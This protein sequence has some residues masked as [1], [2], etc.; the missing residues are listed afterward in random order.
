MNGTDLLAEFRDKG[1]EA[2]FSELVRR[3]TNLVYSVA[4]RRVS[5]SALAQEVAQLV[6]IRLA[7]AVPKLR[8]DAELVAWLHR[9]TVHVSIDLWRS[10]MRRHAREEQAVAMQPDPAED[11]AWNEMAPVVDEAL[12]ALNDADRQAILLRFFEQKSMRD[13]ALAFGISEDAAKMRVSRALDRLRGQ[14]GGH[15][16][17]CASVLALGALLAERS[18]EAAPSQLVA[19]L[20]ALRIPA[21]AGAGAG[22]GIVAVAVAVAKSKL[23]VGAVAALVSGGAVLMWMSRAGTDGARPIAAPAETPGITQTTEPA[24]SASNVPTAVAASTEPQ[25]ALDPARLLR[26][27][28]R[29]RTRIT[30]GSVEFEVTTYGTAL[31]R[32]A[33]NQVRIQALFDGPK[34]RFE[35]FGR[36]YSYAMAQPG[37]PD[38]ETIT[39]RAD[40]MDREAAVRAGLLE[41]FDSHH[42]LIYDET[43]LMDYWET[44][45]PYPR[46]T[47]DEPGKGTPSYIFDPRCLGITT[48]FFIRQTVDQCL[49]WKDAKSIVFAGQENVEGLPA[50]HLRV[51]K[52]DLWMDLWL[53]AVRT[54]RVLKYGFNGAFAVSKFAGK[55][56]NDPLPSQVVVSEYRNGAVWLER[57]FTGIKARFELPVPPSTWTL[58]GLGMKIGAEVIDVRVQR[59]IGYWTG[60]GLSDNPGSRNAPAQSGPDRTQ[61]FAL[62]ESE[63][64]SLA[65]LQAAG[66][67]LMNTPDGPDVQKAADVIVQEHIQSPDL[68]KLSQDLERMRHAGARKLLEAMVERNPHAEV[69]GNACFTLA[70]WRKDEADYGKNK[71]ATAE[72]EKLFERVIK[73]FGREKQR[74]YTL[75]ELATPELNELRRLTIG[76]TAPEIAGEDLDG[77][78]LKLSSYRGK[79]VVLLFWSYGCPMTEEMREFNKLVAQMRGKPFAF[80]GIHADDKPDRARAAAE[81][82]EMSFRS[83]SDARSGPIAKAWNNNSWPNLYVLDRK[84]IIRYRG[85][86]HWDLEKAVLTLL[87]E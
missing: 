77:H 70:K 37:G 2:A 30:S 52:S 50:L 64:A 57:V 42:V 65:A 41:P 20:A 58:A 67:I 39:K 85:L 25:A 9:T 21:A 33:T 74:G 26:S 48:G 29:A 53:D 34:L 8:T 12:N 60:S 47:I 84:G 69:R 46:T 19:T 3:Y 16:V 68:L 45:S 43:S 87:G 72:A 10:E 81:K 38:A 73:E 66:W 27:V 4:H 40:S 17:P 62:L 13:L 82:Y 51:L 24:D 31:R 71:Q 18:V 63:P 11:A 22:A 23:L 49:G 75:A 36:E 44:G 35:S 5:Q 59:G 79:V 56:A 1:A 61:L 15:G 7:K 83:F 80:L 32:G 76:K 54:N 6:F 14:L 28:T 55:S 86:R 78:P